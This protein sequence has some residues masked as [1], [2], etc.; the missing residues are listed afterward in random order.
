MLYGKVI[1]STI[2]QIV[3]DCDVIKVKVP[4]EQIMKPNNYD[5]NE[6]VWYWSYNK[7]NYYYDVGEEVCVKVIDLQFKTKTDITSII[8]R[9]I[10]IEKNQNN[11]MKVEGENGT[12]EQDENEVI[13]LT[14][15]MIMEVTCTMSEEGLGP[16]KWW[17]ETKI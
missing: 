15:D 2:N 5:E 13:E 6:N 12:K 3:V 10:E 9:N 17:K 8:N 16:L 4:S 14:K 7:S 1:H 11:L